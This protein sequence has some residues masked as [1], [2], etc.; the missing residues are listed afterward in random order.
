[1]II[2]RLLK[3]NELILFILVIILFLFFSISTNIFFQLRNILLIFQ[4][5]VELGL[6]TFGMAICLI[7]G[8][9]DLSIGTLC[10]FNTVIIALFN[11]KM[12]LP[13]PIALLIALSFS[14][15]CGLI[16]GYLIG[17][18][19]IAPM[20]VTIGTQALFAG[21]GL[22]ITSGGAISGFN[23]TY[24]YIGNGKLFG[25]FPVQ[26][27]ILIFVFFVILIFTQFTRTGR[28]IYLI[29][30]NSNVARFSGINRERV[31]MIVYTTSSIMAFFCAIVLSARL[32]TGRPDIADNYLMQTLAAAIIGGVSISGGKGSMS[33]CIL[34]V[35]VFQIL[36]NGMVH[37][38]SINASYYEQVMIGILLLGFL[39]LSSLKSTQH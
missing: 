27:F 3:N 25:V 5:C 34:G 19:K 9:I 37:M 12:G 13:I 15:M 22:L 14:L 1:M 17:Y 28:C 11:A 23:N 35:L 21:M 8:G 31:L 33:G 26:I 10:S 4:K 7:S 38:I 16:N 24:T 18:I 29:G 39:T 20:L 6:L 36:S 32:A 2:K 30:S